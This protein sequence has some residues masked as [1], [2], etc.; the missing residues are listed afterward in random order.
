MLVMYK[1]I[2]DIY[3]SR[4]FLYWVC[5]I[6]KFFYGVEKKGEGGGGYVSLD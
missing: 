3:L 2:Y 1:I 5:S 6:L 4:E